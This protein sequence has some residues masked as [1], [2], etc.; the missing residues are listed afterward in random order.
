[1][2][3][4]VFVPGKLANPLNGS[5]GHWTTRAKWAREWRARTHNRLWVAMRQHGLPHDFARVEQSDR[6][7]RV[8]FL[9]QT[10]NPVDDDALPGMCK[11]AR[12]GLK[13]AG[14]IHN[15]G[16]E[17]GHVFTYAQ[18]VKRDHRGVLITVEPV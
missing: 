14:I 10:H 5:H 15:D 12:N 17:S 13:D 7:K 8:S 1:M 3:L 18:A 2:R 4:E 9:V 11:P 16:P 6:P